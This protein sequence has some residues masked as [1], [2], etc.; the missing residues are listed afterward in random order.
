MRPSELP[1]VVFVSAYQLPVWVWPTVL[2][3]VCAV[4]LWRGKDDERLAA[5]GYLAAWA[6]SMVAF[7]AKS[8]DLQWGVL[9]VDMGLLALYIWLAL[10]SRRH[11]PLFAAGFQL[12]AIITHLGRAADT[13]IS[14]WA[15]ITAEIIWSYLVLF[16]IAYGSWTQPYVEKALA[17][18]TEDPGATRR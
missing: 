10:R 3:A 4:A 2:M 16:A 6:L 17:A 18:A 9:A 8:R 11:W 12:L 7:K 5:A 1:G 15:Y 14:G 13:G